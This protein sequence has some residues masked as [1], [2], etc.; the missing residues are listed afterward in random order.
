M[1]QVGAAEAGAGVAAAARIDRALVLAKA[2]IA[3]AQVLAGEYLSPKQI[4]AF[5]PAWGITA[6]LRAVNRY[7]DAA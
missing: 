5:L 3:Q 1:V 2:R 7:L 4:L 6:S